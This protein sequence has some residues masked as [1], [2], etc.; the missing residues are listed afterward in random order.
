MMRKPLTATK[1]L[2]LMAVMTAIALTIF[3]IENQLPAPAPIPGVKYGLANIITLTA[4]LTLGR[5]EAGAILLARIILGALFAASPSTLLYSLA[6]GVLS[7]ALMC[8]LT[9]VF[10]RKMLWLVSALCGLAHNAGQLIACVLI[11]KTPGV[12]AYAPVLAVSGIITGV[13][14]GIA[15][16][17][18][19]RALEKVNL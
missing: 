4:M 11:V 19:I 17:Q 10:P 14:T 8:V 16:A 5:K 3:V 15:A 18:L 7:Y 2:C 12:F 1:K 6:G 13:F 9:A